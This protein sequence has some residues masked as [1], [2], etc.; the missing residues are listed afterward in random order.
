[1]SF[2]HITHLRHVDLAVADYKQQVTFYRDHWGLTEVATDSGVSYFAAA[3]SPEQYVI[4]VRGSSDKRIDL[5][6]FGAK[7][8]AAVDALAE[9]LGQAG[10]SLITEPDDLQTPGSGYG[11][12]FFDLEGRTVE[13]SADVEARVH[14]R[15]E[16]KEDIPVR[17]SHVVLNSPEPEKMLAW[18]EKHLGFRLSDTLNHPRVGD[19]FY[20]LRCSPQHHSMAIARGPHPSLQHVSFELRGIDE[21]MRGSG[22]LMRAG[23]EKIWGPGRHRAGE[24]AFSYFIDPNGNTM[25]YTTELETVDEDR[26]HPHVYDVYE[27][28]TSDVWGTANPMDDFITQKMFN[29]P[30]KGLF[31]PPPV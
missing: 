11:F 7:D 31:V 29:D 18:Y 28:E 30:D 9:Q 21:Y 5:V 23:W 3:G 4:R 10:V 16:E 8:P 15:I 24:N 13:V 27:P 22:R 17:L 1:M 20:F 12:R 25:E 26:W 2:S 14:R 19:I 6:S